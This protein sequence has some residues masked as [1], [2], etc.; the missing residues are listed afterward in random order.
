MRV[1]FLDI[2]G[3]LNRTGYRPDESVDLR[4]WIEA[5]LATRL[6]QLVR[7]LDASIVLA[8]D[9]R[10]GRTLEHL[11]GE[12][13]A[14]GVDCSLLGVTPVLGQARWREIDAW[15]R[16]H[17]VPPEHVVIVD[18]GYDM[19]ALAARFVRCSP[20]H[21][22]DEDAVRAIKLLFGIDET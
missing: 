6:S 4:S 12:L 9:W 13:R 1:L 16:E 5:E 10:N 7:A 8:S 14:A 22:L 17:D 11:A 3:V 21:G 20:L 19:G 18:D 2:D 15:M